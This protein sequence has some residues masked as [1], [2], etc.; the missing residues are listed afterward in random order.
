MAITTVEGI[1]T[2]LKQTVQFWRTPTSTTTVLRMHSLTL[3]GDPA[4]ANAQFANTTNGTL[5]TSSTTGYPSLQSFNGNTGYITAATI[6]GTTAGRQLTAMLYDRLLVV[7]TFSGNVAQTNISTHPDFSGRLPGGSYEGLELWLDAPS[8]GWGAA[9]AIK[10]DYLNQANSAANTGTV[11]N[12]LTNVGDMVRLPLATGDTGVR[13]ITAVTGGPA[14]GNF[15]VSIMR[16]L[17]S[18]AT[19]GW[20]TASTSGYSY[21]N[22]A[23]MTGLTRIYDTTALLPVMCPHNTTLDRFWIEVEIGVG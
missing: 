17:C 3:A 4:A 10:I 11:S 2:A 22:G 14:T 6:A 9:G 19:D 5:V 15:N 18:V 21:V 7:G 23:P 13:A 1:G 8:T 20:G 12:T 16:R